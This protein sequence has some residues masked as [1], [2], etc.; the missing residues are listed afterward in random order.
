[1]Q[2]D[3][4]ILGRQTSKLMSHT[5]IPLTFYKPIAQ[6]ERADVK[7]QSQTLHHFIHALLVK[8]LC[9]QRFIY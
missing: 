6:G 2:Q 7:E 5:F 4:G 3:M 9:A 8:K 1:M